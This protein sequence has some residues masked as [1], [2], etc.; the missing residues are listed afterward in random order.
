[1]KTNKNIYARLK[2][3]NMLYSLEKIAPCAIKKVKVL[4]SLERLIIS[5][6]ALI[7]N[8]NVHVSLSKTPPCAIKQ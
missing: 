4:V 8:I 3:K 1:M 7:K 5:I 6:C 2:N